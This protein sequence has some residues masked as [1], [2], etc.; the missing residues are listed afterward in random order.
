[1]LAFCRSNPF[2]RYLAP[3]LIWL[4]ASAA[5]SAVPHSPLTWLTYAI[6]VIITVPVI[7]LL[8]K[9]H[10]AEIEGR[11]DRRAVWAGLAVLAAWLGNYTLCCAHSSAAFNPAT[12][13]PAM[14]LLAMTVRLA[15]AST[16]VP[17]L[18][19]T[20]WRSFLM[21]FLIR[22]DFLS[23]PL[24]TY[25]AWAFWITT[26]IFAAMHPISLWPAAAFAGWA[27]GMYLVK[28]KNLVGC[29]IAHGVTNLGL[30]LYAIA[31]Q[32]WGL[33]G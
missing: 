8:F 10:W 24:G 26:L 21:R 1:M 2:C 27:Y 32:E 30:G 16:V 14:A 33:W 4:L 20:V 17:F 29:M 13:S 7:L 11:F 9:G 22:N 23:V 5:Q 28:T 25:S 31:T 12:L 6:K 15:G 18:E 3:F 19:E